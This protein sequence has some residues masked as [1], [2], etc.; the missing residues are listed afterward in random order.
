ML[1]YF[2]HDFNSLYY[3]FANADVKGLKVKIKK[4]IGLLLESDFS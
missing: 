2:N 3:F 4:S 1:N